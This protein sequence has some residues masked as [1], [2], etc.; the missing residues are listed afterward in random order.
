MSTTGPLE[1]MTSEQD[2]AALDGAVNLPRTA[3]REWFAVVGAGMEVLCAKLMWLFS[4]L[5]K[6]WE[7][8]S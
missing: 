4:A 5:G 8:M 1:A 7:E 6:S 2:M 3:V